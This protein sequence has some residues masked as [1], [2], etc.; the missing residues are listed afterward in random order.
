MSAN[1]SPAGLALM[2]QR[3]AE[4]ARFF[5]CAHLKATGAIFVAICRDCRVWR[6]LVAETLPDDLDV[7]FP[8]GRRFRCKGC[9]SSYVDIG[10]Q[11]GPGDPGPPGIPGS[12]GFRR[13]EGG[14]A[15][16]SD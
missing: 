15:G 3:E 16:R 10:F 2:R 8:E 13:S 7:R 9:G 4:R 5:T 14:T 12:E 6:Y 1:K 11:R